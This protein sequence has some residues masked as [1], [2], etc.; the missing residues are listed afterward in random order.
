MNMPVR[1]SPEIQLGH[2]VQIIAVIG[3]VAGWALWGYATI[4]AQLSRE[5]ATIALIQQRLDVD[6]KA[7]AQD[8]EAVKSFDSDMRAAVSKI[9]DQISDLKALVA[10]NNASRH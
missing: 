10:A 4:Q 1:F 3:T 2:I 6:E 8:R 7:V 9:S 5:D